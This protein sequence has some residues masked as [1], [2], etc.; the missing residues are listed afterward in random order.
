MNVNILT[1]KKASPS[2][3][4]KKLT[5]FEVSNKSIEFLEFEKQKLEMENQKINQT[6]QNKTLSDKQNV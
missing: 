2:N 6:L 5:N 3:S 4:L 1:L